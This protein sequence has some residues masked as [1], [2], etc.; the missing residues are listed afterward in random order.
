M[1]CSLRTACMRETVFA[2]GSGG[3]ENHHLQIPDVE[4][5]RE[6]M[7]RESYSLFIHS[8]I[9][10]KGNIWNA[11]VCDQRWGF[12]SH[13]NRFCQALR[14]SREPMTLVGTKYNWAAACLVRRGHSSCSGSAARRAGPAPKHRK[15][16]GRDLQ[17]RSVFLTC[18]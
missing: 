2:Q 8:F 12:N 4:A 10:T 3:P 9:R 5:G 6:T 7:P 15:S 18:S 16:T 11:L 1:K 14:S 17:E 13:Q